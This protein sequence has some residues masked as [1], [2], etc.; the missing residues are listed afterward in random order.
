MTTYI[1]IL[2]GLIVFL[3]LVLVVLVIGEDSILV[4]E[5]LEVSEEV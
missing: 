5:V 4:V 1:F 2:L 3:L